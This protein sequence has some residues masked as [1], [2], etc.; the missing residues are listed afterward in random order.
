MKNTKKKLMEQIEDLSPEEIAD[1]LSGLKKNKKR[2]TSTP[3]NKKRKK[4]G[5]KMAIPVP[6]DTDTKRPNRFTKHG[7][8]ARNG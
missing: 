3:N 4:D 5:K 8:E 6:L 2:G 1:L 7:Y